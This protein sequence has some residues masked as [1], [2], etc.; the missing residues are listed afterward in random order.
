[1]TSRSAMIYMEDEM[2]DYVD[3]LKK[4]RGRGAAISDVLKADKRRRE[5]EERRKSSSELVADQKTA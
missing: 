5:R 3:Q 1:M 2:W 4:D